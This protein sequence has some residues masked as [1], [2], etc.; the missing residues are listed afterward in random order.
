MQRFAHRSRHDLLARYFGLDQLRQL[1]GI[2]VLVLGQ[3]ELLRR[4]GRHQRVQQLH[5]FGRNFRL[6]NFV[7]QRRRLG[8][9]AVVAELGHDD[10]PGE[11]PQPDNVFL[12]VHYDLGDGLAFLFHHAPLQH[13][14][15][16]LRD[17]AI[18][19]KIVRLAAGIHGV[20]GAD[21]NE[22]IDLDGLVAFG[23]QLVEF[24]GIDDDVAVLGVLVAGD[25][26]ALSDPVISR[27]LIHW[28]T[29]PGS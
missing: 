20:E 15:A 12:A 18:G 28:L 13:R 10:E 21:G 2:A 27:N 16:L 6:D 24:V 5:L 14:V 25:D 26:V 23:P 7:G 22:G 1:E 8:H 29:F 11:R 17:R 19:R 4:A 3:V 9:L